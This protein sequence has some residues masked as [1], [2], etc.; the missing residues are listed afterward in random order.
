MSSG[1]GV[2][3]TF[4]EPGRYELVTHEDDQ[5]VRRLGRRWAPTT[6]S[7]CT[8]RS[9]AT[10]TIRSTDGRGPG[11]GETPGPGTSGC[12]VPP[13]ADRS[14]SGSVYGLHPWARREVGGCRWS[15]VY[16][17]R[18][19]SRGTA[20]WFRWAARRS[21]PCSRCCLLHA[22]EPVSR[23]LLIDGLWTRP[24]DGAVHA[25]E[26]RVSALRK[27][28]REPVLRTR[29]GGYLIEVEV[30]RLDL[31]RFETWL[32]EG[33]EALAD[34]DARRAEEL[35]SEA[36]AVWRG[37]P[38]GGLA[39][40]P[41]ALAE[42]GR[43]EEERLCC[44]RGAGG[45]AARAGPPRRARGRAGRA[46]G[47]EPAAGALS[48]PADAGAL[49]VRAPGRGAR[50]VPP[51]T[52]AA[53]GRARDRTGSRP[54]GAAGGDPPPR[55]AAR[56]AG[57]RGASQCR[58]RCRPSRPAVAGAAEDRDDALLRRQ[59]LDDARRADS[60]RRRCAACSTGTSSG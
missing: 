52:V 7:S 59:R 1:A 10:T 2:L 58:R 33:R 38:L 40:E 57:D 46:G 49:P 22:N 41:V 13:M 32:G 34:G 12:G 50:G 43:L 9:S 14:V 21:G 53:G 35:L 3:A 16:W 23:D 51:R 37:P 56:S 27:R 17:D 25:L 42:A 8:C 31:L 28:L 47:G 26:A 24:P 55:S 36:L 18:S 39:F 60:T 6:S 29:P 54:A 20:A 15:S 44:G 5:P 4:T 11:A 45:G 19:R 48:A 30:G